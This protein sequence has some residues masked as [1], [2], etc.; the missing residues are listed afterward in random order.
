MTEHAAADEP[1]TEAAASPAPAPQIARIV[2]GKARSETVPL[3]WPVEF[4]GQTYSEITVSR[5]NVA[6]IEAWQDKL[7]EMRLRDE[8]TSAERLPMFGD[9]PIA[10]LRGLDPDD[11]DRIAEVVER[12]LPQRYRAEG[13]KEPAPPSGNTTPTS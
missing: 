1:T 5:P 7:A 12:F 9:T 4:A 13:S 10:V 6:Q 11:D 2:A 3:E 8:D